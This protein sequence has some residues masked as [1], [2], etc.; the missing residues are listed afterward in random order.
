[1]S[2]TVNKKRYL[3][4]CP[5]KYCIRVQGFLDESWSDRLAGL[6]I[7]TCHT[8]DHEP[9]SELV[10]QVRDQAELAGEHA[11]RSAPDPADGRV[12]ERRLSNRSPKSEFGIQKWEVAEVKVET[13]KP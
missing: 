8:E 6:R 7:T 5:G 10:G 1:M 13:F 3:F 2:E 12:P 4:D 11:L 9:I